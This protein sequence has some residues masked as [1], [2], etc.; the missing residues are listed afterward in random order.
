[1]VHGCS[2]KKQCRHI[3]YT[4]FRDLKGVSKTSPRLALTHTIPCIHLLGAL[5]D[6][7]NRTMKTFTPALRAH[8][9]SSDNSMGTT[10]R[11][12][13]ETKPLFWE[14]SRK[15]CFAESTQC[16]MRDLTLLKKLD[17]TTESLT[18]QKQAEHRFIDVI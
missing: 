4:A 15:T 1:M 2:G 3:Q 14:A 12:I 6:S 13:G 18:S 7:T 8:M 11:Q 5:S 17:L 16:S 9:I 10:A